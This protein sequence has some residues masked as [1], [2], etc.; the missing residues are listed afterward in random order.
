M[1]VST[2]TRLSVGVL[3]YIIMARYLGPTQFG[4]IA[5]AMAYSGL[6]GLL[7]DYGMGIFGLRLAGAEPDRTVEIVR[8]SLLVKAAMTT[9]AGLL[10]ALLLGVFVENPTE[11]RIQIVIFIATMMGSFADLA[12][13]SVRAVRRFW[14]ETRCVAWTSALSSAVLIGVVLVTGDAEKASWGFLA[15]RAI[16]VSGAVWALQPWLF[17]PQ[18]PWPWQPAGLKTMIRAATPYAVD[19]ALTNVSNQ[20]DIVMVSMLLDA[21]AVGI[22]QAGARIVQSVVPFAVILSTVYLP[23]LA[24]AHFKSDSIMLRHLTRRLNMEFLILAF[25]SCGSIIILG[26]IWTVYVLGAKYNSLLPLWAGFGVFLGTRFLSASFGLQLA[27]MGELLWRI[28]AQVTTIV[29]IVALL[30]SLRKTLD[31]ET[32]IWSVVS[33]NCVLVVVYA[34]GSHFTMQRRPVPEPI[35]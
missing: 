35:K 32:T 15:S 27:A 12:F 28:S 30:F 31:L 22:Y 4:L 1:A 18:S 3:V 29:L 8:R 24:N 6:L 11:A 17:A 7:S 10:G 20:I 14:V 21:T 25:L 23:R 9:L 5:K 2:F 19:G 16:Y 13:V 34:V 33:A 26:P